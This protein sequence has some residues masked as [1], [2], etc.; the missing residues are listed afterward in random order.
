[1]I[2]VSF[3]PAGQN[4]STRHDVLSVFYMH[5]SLQSGL[6]KSGSGST[7]VLRSV[8]VLRLKCRAQ[9]LTCRPGREK[10]TVFQC[11]MT[12]IYV[13][14]PDGIYCGLR[15]F[16]VPAHNRKPFS[17]VSIQVPITSAKLSPS[18]DYVWQKKCT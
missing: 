9:N 14:N 12:S 3:L 11:L 10:K 5:D 16:I 17:L 13:E 2:Y 15:G 6:I 8:V 1:M 4:E 7:T 18:Q